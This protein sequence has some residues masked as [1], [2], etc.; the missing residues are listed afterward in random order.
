MHDTEHAALSN[1]SPWNDCRS[2]VWGVA[3]LLGLAILFAT[4][5]WFNRESTPVHP[6]RIVM[7]RPALDNP[8]TSLEVVPYQHENES[9]HSDCPASTPVG[10]ICFIIGTGNPAPAPVT[11]T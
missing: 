11:F 2:P 7:L 8:G 9:S 5:L 1:S 3:L 6:V 4:C 10:G